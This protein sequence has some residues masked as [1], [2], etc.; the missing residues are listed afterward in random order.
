M[1]RPTR[2]TPA[3]ARWLLRY[4]F[5]KKIF[6]CFVNS[7]SARLALQGGRKDYLNT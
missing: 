5:K 1:Y 4:V 7:V 6:V 2:N 3:S